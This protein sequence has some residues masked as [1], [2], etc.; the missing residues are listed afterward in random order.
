[1]IKL[2]QFTLIAGV[3]SACAATNDGRRS[4]AAQ[5]SNAVQADIEL[6]DAVTRRPLEPSSA[7]PA[8]ITAEPPVAVPA[9]QPQ[10]TPQ[11]AITYSRR[12]H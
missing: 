12:A 6:V 1:M 7:E 9:P 5:P 11:P 4:S 8:P 3:L 2:I 10:P